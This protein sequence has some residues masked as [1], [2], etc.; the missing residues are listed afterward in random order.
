MVAIPQNVIDIMNDKGTVKALVT[1]NKAGQPHAIVCGT[2]ACPAPDKMVV[3]E[4]L[5]KRSAEYMAENG[6]AAFLIS[7]G[8]KAYEIQVENPVRFDSGDALAQMNTM[9]A[10]VNLH[11]KALWMFDVVA[12]YD[13][14]AGPSAGTKLA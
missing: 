6:K 1:A 13:E 10:A 4:V 9:L 14:S 3:G 12:V 8:P 11:A 7:A 5:M 2:I